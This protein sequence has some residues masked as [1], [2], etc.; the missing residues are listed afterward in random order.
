MRD[1]V[2]FSVKYRQAIL[3]MQAAIVKFQM[4]KLTAMKKIDELED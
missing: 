1:L 2:N 3:Q 4:M